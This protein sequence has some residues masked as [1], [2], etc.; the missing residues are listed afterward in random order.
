[1]NNRVLLDPGHGWRESKGHYGRPLML[2]QEDKV[3]NLGLH[4]NKNKLSDLFLNFEGSSDLFYREDF[5]TIAIASAVKKLSQDTDLEIFM[6][7]NPK[8]PIDAK[9]YLSKELNATTWQKVFWGRAHWITKARKRY[10]CDTVVSIHTNAGGGSGVTSFYRNKRA[11]LRLASYITKEITRYSPLSYRGTKQRRFALL[12]GAPQGCLVE[13]G[14]H[15]N[16]NDLKVLLDPKGVEQ[17]AQGIL[18]GILLNLS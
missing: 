6:T 3:Y 5:G 18:K 10:D 17:I 4:G 8:D 11:G 13:C 1:M 12:R 14:F 7:R 9:G 2:L 15:D 16:P